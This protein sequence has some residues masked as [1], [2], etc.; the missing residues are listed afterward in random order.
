LIFG[1]RSLIGSQGPAAM[2]STEFAV[3]ESDRL[4]FIIEL[5]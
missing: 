5:K 2:P 4:P 3:Q 1:G